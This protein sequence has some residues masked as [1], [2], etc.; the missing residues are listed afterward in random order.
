MLVL[1]DK[2]VTVKPFPPDVSGAASNPAAG[3]GGDDGGDGGGDGDDAWRELYP[4]QATRFLSEVTETDEGKVRNEA[5]ERGGG[6]NR[7]RT[8][9]RTDSQTNERGGGRRTFSLCSS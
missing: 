7:E 8:Y 9:V 6:A 2:L 5:G 4:V 3:D 1:H